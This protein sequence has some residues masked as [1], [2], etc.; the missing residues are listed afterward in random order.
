MKFHICANI[1][2]LLRDSDKRLGRLLGMPGKQA[3]FELQ[4]L[5]DKGHKL[6]PSSGCDNFDPF[7]HGCLGHTDDGEKNPC[8]IGRIGP[9]GCEKAINKSCEGCENYQPA[10][11]KQPELAE[12][13]L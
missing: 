4:D 13:L 5:K 6:I 9:L 8:K 11:K 3:R 12:E 2:G 1:E 10:R 7:E